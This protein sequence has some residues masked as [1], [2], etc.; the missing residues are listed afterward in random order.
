MCNLYRMTKGVSE[1]AHL[2]TVLPDPGA[3]FAEEIY[4]GYTGLVVAD[5]RARP[6]TWGYPLALKGRQGQPLKPKPV[7]NARDDKLLTGFWL[8]SFKSRRCLIPVTNWA[9]PEGGKGKMTRTWYALEEQDTFAVAGLWTPTVKWGDAY[10]MVM[11]E[12]C[13][14]M[15]EV[16]DRMPVILS[17]DEWSL[18]TQ[19][20]AS[21]ALALCRTY[22]APL[23]VLR[24]QERWAG[25]PVQVER[26]PKLL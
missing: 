23:Q 1:I 2:F 26:Q 20:T 12:A 7:T 13:A 5:G 16:H 24:T 14:Q 18:W 6:M 8:P 22:E 3:N 15:A 10:T 4:P 25:E 9:E 19:G 17:R 21:E 11:T